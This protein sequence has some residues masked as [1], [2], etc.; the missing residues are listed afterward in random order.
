MNK[1]MNNKGFSL[2]ELIIVIAI[3]AILVG[4]LAPQFIKYIESSRQST[5]IDTVAAYKTAIEAQIID[6]ASSGT[7]IT[8]GSITITNGTPCT[9][10][11]DLD[12][13]DVGITGTAASPQN[14][15]S[16]GWGA[17]TYTYEIPSG[18]DHYQWTNASAATDKNENANEPK[19][20]LVSAFR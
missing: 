4:V 8:S 15:R 20:D 19:K 3:M 1:K 17:K 16:S 6:S 10:Q 5:D 12:L 7:P 14:L 13:S 18:G 9:I 2:V 11:S